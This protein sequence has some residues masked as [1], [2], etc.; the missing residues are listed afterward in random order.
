MRKI[1]HEQEINEIKVHKK[2]TIHDLSHFYSIS[3][4][5]STQKVHMAISC[6]D[7]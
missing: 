2:Y 3:W 5:K 7:F 4:N 6:K 1:Q